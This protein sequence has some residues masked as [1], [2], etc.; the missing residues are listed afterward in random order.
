MI[1][2]LLLAADALVQNVPSTIHTFEMMFVEAAPEDGVKEPFRVGKTE[3]SWDLLDAYRFELDRK[4]ESETPKKEKSDSIARPSKPYIAMDRSFGHNG[5]PAISIQY[6]HAR[7]FARWLS[8]KTDRHYRLPT[9]SE[10]KVLASRSGVTPQNILDH[11]WLD[12]NADWVTHPLGEK[13]TDAL[14]LH[15]LFGNAS[16]WV[17]GPNGEHLTYG[18]CY[19]TLAKDALPV[20]A[21]PE[22]M[23]NWNASDPQ[24]PQSIWW[25]ADGG[26]VGIRLVLELDGEG[27]PEPAPAKGVEHETKPDE[28]P[29]DAKPNP[30]R[31]KE[32]GL[33]Q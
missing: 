18:G 19:E 10:W 16:E 11:A 9:E 31:L 4:A 8:L 28:S 26:F 30:D 7:C 15:D 5:Y 20:K 33:S 2:P 24:D 29:E 6:R 12:E 14:G 13:K 32:R 27:K 3:V 21:I 25:L 1:L 17:S 22:D 23:E